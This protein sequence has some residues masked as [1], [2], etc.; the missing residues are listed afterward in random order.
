MKEIWETHWVFILGGWRKVL[1]WRRELDAESSDVAIGQEVPSVNW[2]K[3]SGWG[4]NL[5][6]TKTFRFAYLIRRSDEK[7]RD[8]VVCHLILGIDPLSAKRWFSLLTTDLL[9]IVYSE[10]SNAIHCPCAFFSG[11][12]DSWD[13]DFR[14]TFCLLALVV[15]KSTSRSPRLEKP[16]KTVSPCGLFSLADFFVF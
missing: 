9:P 16:S 3:H 13:F 4:A 7:R 12:V 6:H 14:A 1:R 5:L 2:T 11:L 8:R 10:F 15:G